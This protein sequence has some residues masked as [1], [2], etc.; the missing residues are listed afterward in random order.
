MKEQHCGGGSKQN[1]KKIVDKEPMLIVKW[2]RMTENS[3]D[4]EEDNV[5]DAPADRTANGGDS[6][7]MSR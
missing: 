1:G 7:R 6:L 3:S 4:Y 5:E 2:C